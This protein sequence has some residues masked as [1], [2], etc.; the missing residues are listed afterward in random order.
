LGERNKPLQEIVSKMI[1][2]IGIDNVDISRVERIYR[3]HGDRFLQRV[4]APAERM[5]IKKWKSP[6]A[7]IAARFA[8]KEACMKALG[9]GWS[10]GVRWK[11]IEVTNAPDGRPALSLQGEA[12]KRFNSLQ[13]RAAHISITHSKNQATALVI[14]E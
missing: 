1:K 10:Q 13:A 2:G 7:R 5:Y 9:T 6:A 8:A 3:E 12:K 11:D 14:L 4:L